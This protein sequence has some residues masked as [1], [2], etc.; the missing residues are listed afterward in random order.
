MIVKISI[1]IVYKIGREAA[2]RLSAANT[3]GAPDTGVIHRVIP[4]YGVAAVVVVNH[5]GRHRSKYS[6]TECI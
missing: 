5:P 2:A 6:G 3:H 4:L 1:V